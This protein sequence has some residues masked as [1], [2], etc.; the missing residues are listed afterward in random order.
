MILENLYHQANAFV[1]APIL[2]FKIN[3]I[4]Q[5][6]EIIFFKDFLIATTCPD[7]Q[8]FDGKQCKVCHSVCKTC[9]GPANYNCIVCDKI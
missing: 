2:I 9:D 8:F 5:M 4:A 6:V 1:R 3:L 7:G